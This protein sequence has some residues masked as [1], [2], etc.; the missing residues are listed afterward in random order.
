MSDGINID[1]WRLV[2]A[3]HELGHAFAWQDAGVGF[4][5][6]R[7][8]GHGRSTEG[9]VPVDGRRLRNAEQLRLYLIGLYAGSAASE[10][11]CDLAGMRHPASGCRHDLATARQMRRHPWARNLTDGELRTGARRAVGRHWSRIHRLAP[12][13]AD[14]GQIRI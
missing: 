5:M 10:R 1:R 6:I 3:A 8:W 4:G 2:V 12:K 7:V 13:L 9:V 11:W 14:R